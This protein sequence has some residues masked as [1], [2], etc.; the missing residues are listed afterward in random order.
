LN[1]NSSSFVKGEKSLYCCRSIA[2]KFE[3][4][5]LLFLLPIPAGKSSSFF[6]RK[7]NRHVGLVLTETRTYFCCNFLEVA[8]TDVVFLFLQCV[9]FRFQF[10]PLFKEAKLS[11]GHGFD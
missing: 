1:F 8:H 10:A 11:A 7:A 6:G 9:M 3:Y 2:V 4:Y 5:F